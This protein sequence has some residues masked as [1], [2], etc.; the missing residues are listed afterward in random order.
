[1]RPPHEVFT[2]VRTSG[3]AFNKTVYDQRK[4][5]RNGNAVWQPL[6]LLKPTCNTKHEKENDSCRPGV[7][8]KSDLCAVLTGAS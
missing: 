4:S 7:K 2:L 6:N 1:M 8:R 3:M 5:L